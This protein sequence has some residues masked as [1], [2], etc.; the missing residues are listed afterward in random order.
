MLYVHINYN[1]HTFR[2]VSWRPLKNTH[3]ILFF[4]RRIELN[5]LIFFIIDLIVFSVLNPEESPKTLLVPI[6]TKI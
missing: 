4:P 3:R 6:K 2:H 5:Y 1:G